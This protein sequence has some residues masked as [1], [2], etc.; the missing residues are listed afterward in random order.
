MENKLNAK[1][2]ITKVTVRY[3]PKYFRGNPALSAQNMQRRAAIK[4]NFVQ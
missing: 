3:S 1:E 4:P 2:E